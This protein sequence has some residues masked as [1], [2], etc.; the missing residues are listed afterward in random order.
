MKILM[1][2]NVLRRGGAERVVC[3]LSNEWTKQHDVKIALFDASPPAYEFGGRLIDLKLPAPTLLHKAYRLVVGSLRLACL[4]RRERPDRIVTFMESANFPATIGAAI[5]GL[6][7]KLTV[8]VHT[9]PSI[10][11]G[12]Y[13]ILLPFLYPLAH[14]VVVPSEGVRQGLQ[15]LGLPTSKLLVINN[16]VSP[17]PFDANSER[18]F[19]SPFVLGA[20]RLT[21]N[22]GFDRLL[23]AFSTVNLPDPHLVILG[24]GPE[25]RR[26]VAIA[27]SLGIGRRVH[28]LGSVSDIETWYHHA[29]CFVLSSHNEGWANVVMEAM[30]NGCPV[31]SFDCQYGPSEI[32]EN[33]VSGLLVPQDDIDGL[34]AAILRLVSDA[35]LRKRIAR[36]G[37]S[38]GRVF[39]VER[40][41]RLWLADAKS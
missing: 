38:R 4:F 7:N 17:R 16:P 23:I 20:G 8:S 13:R 41:A 5:A 40:I 21:K 32:V 34:R 11:P 27:N 37:K 19:P 15:N 12:P 30:A 18:P 9:N 26:L 10:I 22:K 35:E 2:I 1:V 36:A 31:V 29:E 25:H 39:A 3:H 24:E 28:F 14:R 6:L 33:G